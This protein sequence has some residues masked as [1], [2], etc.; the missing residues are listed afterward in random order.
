MQF[1]QTALL[2]F[3]L[4]T[5]TGCGRWALVIFTTVVLTVQ[6]FPLCWL[7]GAPFILCFVCFHLCLFHFK[8]PW[9]PWKALYK[10][11]QL[12]LLI[13]SVFPRGWS[14]SSGVFAHV[15]KQSAK[16]TLPGGFYVSVATRGDLRY[17]TV[18]LCT[19]MSRGNVSLAYIWGVSSF[20]KIHFYFLCLLIL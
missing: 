6:L 20:R 18:H 7:T 11:N 15:W 16:C 1:L 17:I 14:C 19:V 10:L 9:V 3:S 12:L 8:C 2:L 13:L 5:K 4:S